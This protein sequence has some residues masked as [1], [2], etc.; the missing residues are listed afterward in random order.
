MRYFLPAGEYPI[1][2]T[3][4]GS[5]TPHGKE[6]LGEIAT[7][8]YRPEAATES[9]TPSP[10]SR[11]YQFYNALQGHLG[12][13]LQDKGREAFRGLSALFAFRHALRLNLALGV[14]PP[15]DGSAGDTGIFGRLLQPHLTAAPTGLAPNDQFGYLAIPRGD[16]TEVVL[17]GLSPLT[18]FFPAARALPDSLKQV[19][20]WYDF[21]AHRWS[22]PTAVP[23]EEEPT[24]HRPDQSRLK[25]AQGLVRAWLS[26]ILRPARL[27]GHLGIGMGANDRKMVVDEWEMWLKELGGAV[28]TEGDPVI[29]V[30]LSVRGITTDQVPYPFQL[31][32]P[33]QDISE[34]GGVPTHLPTRKGVYLVTKL[35]LEN[36][37]VQIY[38][39][40]YGSLELGL[41]H[42]AAPVS[43]D[44]LGVALGREPWF[45]PIRYVLVDKL[46][47]PKLYALVAQDFQTEVGEEWFVL[48]EIA[49]NGGGNGRSK[50]WLYPFQ[51]EILSYFT[52]DELR[53]NSRLSKLNTLAY[54]LQIPGKPNDPSWKIEK[55]YNDADT[56]V[57]D[58]GFDLRVFPNFSLATAADVQLPHPED[59]RYYMRLRLS[60]DSLNLTW[61]P[62]VS[63]ECPDDPVLRDSYA[64]TPTDNI[65]PPAVKGRQQYA[66]GT[67]YFWVFDTITPPGGLTIKDHGFLLLRLKTPTGNN[68]RVNPQ[69]LALWSVGIDFGTS[70][71]CVTYRHGQVP[72][73]LIFRIMT[74]SLLPT[75]FSIPLG[76]THEGAS[77]MVDFPYWRRPGET[78]LTGGEYF[79]TQIITR[80]NLDKPN[81]DPAQVFSLRNGLAFFRNI[82]QVALEEPATTPII[83]FF[84]NP[85]DTEVSGIAP[86]FYLK[87]RIKWQDI[88]PAD[89]NIFW[90]NVFHA[91]LRLEILLT[92]V[93]H[94]AYVSEVTFSYPRA[95]S[96]DQRRRY[97]TAMEAVWTSHVPLPGG[98]EFKCSR[99]RTESVAAAQYVEV[100]VG[101]DQTL[102]DIGGG[103]TDVTV[104]RS[105][106]LEG[107]TSLRF[108]ADV[109]DDY[110][111][112]SPLFRQ[113]FCEA[114]L[115]APLGGGATTLAAGTDGELLARNLPKLQKGFVDQ[116]LTSEEVLR[117]MWYGFLNI[118]LTSGRQGEGLRRVADVMRTGNAPV[119]AV[120]GF[121]ATA[122]LMFCGLSYFAGMLD[123]HRRQASG[124]VAGQQGRRLS[125]V[126]NGG[127]YIHLLEP[128]GPQQSQQ[129]LAEMF[130]VGAE[131]PERPVCDGLMP[132]PKAAIALG[133]LS[134]NDPDDEDAHGA[135]E[136]A[137]AGFGEPE[138]RSSIYKGLDSENF[139][140]AGNQQ[141]QN[142]YDFYRAILANPKGVT[143]QPGD[144]SPFMTFLKAVD[145][146][147]EKGKL[148]ISPGREVIVPGMGSDPAWAEGLAANRSVRLVQ[149]I[150]ERLRKNAAAY[151]SDLRNHEEEFSAEPLFIT[152]L[153]ALTCGIQEAFANA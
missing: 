98:R 51:P 117:C 130:R 59:R 49:E 28:K 77:A 24:F 17:A 94:H 124:L 129:V 26:G 38:D 82:S 32:A 69:N 121:F 62:L 10:F 30:Q 16:G 5:W 71:S 45:C 6:L 11:A 128:G 42:A 87:D 78:D 97:M 14:T 139:I 116:D 58:P 54:R 138:E 99:S 21:E 85:G 103:T 144:N 146:V 64:R 73:V 20:F 65:Q 50:L 126:G 120:K 147:L 113:R 15:L 123:L 122:T 101:N 34:G 102:L 119:P 89:A 135:A 141:P 132:H 79:P 88:G 80:L 127:R 70:N 105:Q 134:R 131:L 111:L 109:L 107:E 115:A 4:P 75:F 7:G 93:R 118:L 104:F 114:F 96:E 8:M 84:P 150:N 74:S 40:V 92:A 41:R 137:A 37:D 90:R 60:P 25:M 76:N 1:T 143:W 108:A 145:I 110:V 2:T 23:Q 31:S 133:L 83:H 57:L 106:K 9:R 136:P 13:G 3:M 140:L 142:L 18:L 39:S 36:H 12:T 95:F 153:A 27:G 112:H 22:D 91:H 100:A 63:Q 53:A 81:G 56:D 44:N 152:E 72:Q 149:K 35:M 46:F 47:T 52:A 29:S 148:M 66:V 55:I 151:A 86:R 67:D 33:G 43:G 61:D 48:R 68:D 19:L 125:L